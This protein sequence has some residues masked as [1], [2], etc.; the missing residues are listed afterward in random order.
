MNYKKLLRDDNA[1]MNRP[2]SDRKMKPIVNNKY[3]YIT[4]G[5]P[6]VIPVCITYKK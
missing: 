6:K 5:I 4:M 1:Y 2:I 3:L